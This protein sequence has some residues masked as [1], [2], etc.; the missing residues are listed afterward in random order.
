M[1]NLK[2]KRREFLQLMGWGTAGATLAGCDLPT[3]VTLEEGKEEVVAYLS[4][5]EYAIPGVGVWYAS[6]CMQCAAGCGIHGKVREGR[7][8]KLEGN[9][10]SSINRGKLCQMGQAGVQ[11]H[12]NPD[13]YSTPRLRRDGALVD[14]SWDEAWKLIAEKTGA[15]G[16][17]RVAWLTGTLSGHQAAL[18]AAHIEAVQG[19]HYG[20]EVINSA[21][22]EAVNRDLFG[23]AM[24]R[25]HLAKAKLALSFGADFLGAWL[26]PVHF[27]TEYA[28]F[29]KAPRGILVQVEP[30]MSLT[31]ANADLWLAIRPG[32]EGALALGLAYVLAQNGVTAPAV[33]QGVISDYAPSKVAGITGVSEARIM[34]LADLLQKHA[35]SLVLPGHS[36]Q[37]Q[38]QGYETTAAIMLLNV[39]LGNAG[40]T[41]T[42]GGE[43][44]FPQLAAKSGNTRDLIA[45]AEAAHNRAHDVVFFYGANPVFTAPAALNLA[46]RLKNIPFKVAFT[47]FPDETAAACDL[48]MPVASYLEDW[49]THAPAY[50]P[51]GVIGLQ[52]PL[53]ETLYP[54]TPGLGDALLALLKTHNA[55][56]YGAWNN[57]YGYL[58]QAVTS[59]PAQYRTAGQTD[60]AFWQSVLQKGQLKVEVKGGALQVKP[61]SGISL[62]APAAGGEYPLT[63]IPS[64]RLSFWDGRHAN[65]PWIQEAPDQITKV[66]WDSWA[67]IHP[68]TAA[69]LGVEEGDVLEIASE[70]GA[71]K[72]KAFIHKGVHPDAIAVPMGQGHDDYGRYAKNRGANPLRILNPVT[73]ARTGELALY[74]TRVKAAPTGER[75]MLVKAG[76]DNISQ[77]GRKL[78]GTI[79]AEQFRRTEG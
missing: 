11:N 67:E 26:S 37:G 50:Q 60:E 68:S 66:V 28:E 4:P 3:T 31:G 46:D 35:P 79:S 62:S 65:L 20:H 5:E 12:Y 64:P 73:D 22:W 59:L 13:R 1:I 75:Q 34:Q 40:Q 77:R 45:F 8:L 41:I 23:E 48:I 39:M 78:A 2:L 56:K 18:M 72:V 70:Q 38:T 30:A 17:G 10:G 9:P 42:S 53:M 61:L 47:Q 55:A 71:I 24:P 43:F 15:A 27:S 19:K 16:A 49:G 63:L 74:G 76:R 51:D 52:Q 32:T 36:A 54:G 33:L 25:L 58:K 44:P 6:T 7:V 21:V 57:Y 29:R 14:I 69:Q